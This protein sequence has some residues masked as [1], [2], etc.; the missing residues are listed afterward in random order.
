MSIITFPPCKTKTKNEKRKKKKSL[1]SPIFLPIIH[2]DPVYRYAKIQGSSLPPNSKV[3]FF[4][5]S[6]HAVPSDNPQVL[7][8][9]TWKEGRGPIIQVDGGLEVMTFHVVGLVG[10]GGSQGSAG[11]GLDQPVTSFC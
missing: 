5:L 9:C 11:R 3:T 1:K 8:I 4:I 2:V 6:P 7:H 10:S